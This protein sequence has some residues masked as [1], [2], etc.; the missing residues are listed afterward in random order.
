MEENEVVI[1]YHVEHDRFFIEMR[2]KTFDHF[3]DECRQIIDAITG[4][5]ET[6]TKEKVKLLLLVE[7]I[8][9]FS[10]STKLSEK[11]TNN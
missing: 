4:D 5:E 1:S 7:T 11:T 6:N 10:T 9:K 3:I 8:A 2:S